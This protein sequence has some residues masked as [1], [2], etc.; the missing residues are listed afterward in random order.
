ME[1]RNDKVMIRG[2][3]MLS[4]MV[5]AQD[6]MMA[7]K[8][9]GYDTK[10]C[11][12]PLTTDTTGELDILGHDGHP[13][14]V[15]GA[16]VGVLEETDEVCL[17]GL[18]KGEHSRALEAKVC[19]EILSDFTDQALEGQLADQQLRALLVATD[20][21][22]G[23]SSWS[24]SVGLLDSTSSGRGLAGSFRCEL[25]SGSLSTG[26]L[27]SGLLSSSHGSSITAAED[28]KQHSVGLKFSIGEKLS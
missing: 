15:D 28:A 25:L 8:T 2:L 9:P 22:K 10:R 21:T 13:F 12:G 26:G 24:E 27:T 18:L 1:I 6:I 23:D 14:G 3:M 16:Q 19:L 17:R 7:Y 11:L 5:W 4:N 20:L